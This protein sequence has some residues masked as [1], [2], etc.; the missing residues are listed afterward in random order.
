MVRKIKCLTKNNSVGAILQV[1]AH[2]NTVRAAVEN[3]EHDGLLRDVFIEMQK[4]CSDPYDP[5][6]FLS[7]L[8]LHDF[9]G[10]ASD[11]F[12]KLLGRLDDLGESIMPFFLTET[13][14]E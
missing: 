14:D 12:C 9:E 5:S 8:T 4:E 1:L 11:F 2:T 7:I 10:N 3:S 6:E 13:I